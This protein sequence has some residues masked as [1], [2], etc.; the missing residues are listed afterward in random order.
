MKYQ[1]EFTILGDSN[2][3]YNCFLPEAESKNRFTLHVE[4]NAEGITISTAATDSIALK[5]INQSVINLLTVYEKHERH[6]K[7]DSATAND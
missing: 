7:K 2:A 5:A 6:R 3:L 1:A 4:K